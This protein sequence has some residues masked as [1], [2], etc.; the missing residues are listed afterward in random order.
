MVP[1]ASGDAGYWG[2]HVL[3]LEPGRHPG[4]AG[5]RR[6]FDYASKILISSLVGI[7]GILEN[8]D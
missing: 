3:D 8:G 1:P 4:E 6:D 5:Q 2:A 7:L